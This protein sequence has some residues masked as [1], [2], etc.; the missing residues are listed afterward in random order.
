MKVTVSYASFTKQ[1]FYPPCGRNRVLSD[2]DSDLILACFRHSCDGVQSQTVI[3]NEVFV[4]LQV[5]TEVVVATT[6]V[7]TGISTTESSHLF[8]LIF[9]IPVPVR[10]LLI[11]DPLCHHNYGLCK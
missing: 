3:S 4:C 7:M 5:G 1:F 2:Y 8:A 6:R 10:E 9:L 11:S